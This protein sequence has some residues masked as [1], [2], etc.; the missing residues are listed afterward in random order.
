M[1]ARVG[2]AA[3]GDEVG[4][5][6]GDEVGA[7][8]GAA[9]VG[10]RVG[11][12]AVGARVGDEVGARVGGAVATHTQSENKSLPDI[13]FPFYLTIVYIFFMFVIIKCGDDQRS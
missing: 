4:A 11:G 5:R 10:A 13:Q 9:V 7:R 12:A 1:G 3:V 2:G 6:V 8:V